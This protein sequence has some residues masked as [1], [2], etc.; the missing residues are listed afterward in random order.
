MPHADAAANAGRAALLVVALAGRPEQFLRATE[1]RL[2]QE[3]RRSAMPAL[4]LV[5]AL[6]A[7]RAGLVSGAGPDGAGLRRPTTG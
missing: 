1:D 3:Y 4:D 6:R 7:G 2:H 5:A